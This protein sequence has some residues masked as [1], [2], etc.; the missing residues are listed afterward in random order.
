MRPFRLSE[1]KR[2][3]EACKPYDDTKPVY[4]LPADEAARPLN[5]GHRP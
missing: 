4:D 3:A 5:E 1:I 2:P